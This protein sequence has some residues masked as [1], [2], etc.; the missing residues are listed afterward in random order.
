M[1]AI[2]EAKNLR[3]A[4]L[5][6]QCVADRCM[7]WVPDI[8]GIPAKVETYL[9]LLSGKYSVKQVEPPKIESTGRGYCRMIPNNK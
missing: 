1:I 6:R 9:D 5:D 2:V 4:V 3:C 7:A 8:R